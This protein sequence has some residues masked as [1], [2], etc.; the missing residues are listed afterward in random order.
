MQYIVTGGAGFIGAHIARALARKGEYVAVIDDLSGGEEAN[1]RWAQEA[2]TAPILFAKQDCADAGAMRKVFQTLEG[3]PESVLVHCAANA[4]EGASQFQPISVTRRN[5]LA[6]IVTLTEALR[7]GINKVVLFSSMAVYGTGGEIGPPF[8]EG[9]P[10]APEDVYGVN[11]ASMERITEILADVHGFKYVVIRPHNVMGEQQAL[12]DRH[13]NVI[14][15]FMNL[16]MR[17]EPLT[18]YGDG[19][20][21][22]AF[23]YIGDSLPAF[24]HAIQNVE[25]LH[26][27]TINVGGKEAVSINALAE[28]VLAEMGAPED[29]P[30]QYLPD[31]P[32]EVKHAFTSYEKSERLLNYRET[33]GWCYGIRTMAHWAKSVG[34][35]DWR[36]TDS[37]ELVNDKTP[38]PWRTADDVRR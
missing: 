3:G 9:Q 38:A 31:R 12:Y 16:I 22:R 15:I 8:E 24:L 14:G 10:T 35:C 33:I 18:I 26:G 1:V 11:K 20:Q 7:R 19:E 27:E 13:R 23:S 36:T 21:T 4:R 6:Y 25:A 32:C 2:A 17:Q 29:Y 37:L 30:I 28:V 5:L 34:A